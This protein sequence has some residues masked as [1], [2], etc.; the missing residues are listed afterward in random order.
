MLSLSLLSG[1]VSV[2]AYHETRSS[3]SLLQR[4]HLVESPPLPSQQADRSASRPVLYFS[5]SRLALSDVCSSLSFSSFLYFHIFIASVLTT[6]ALSAEVGQNWGFPTYD[7]FV[8]RIPYSCPP[9]HL[10][11]AY[12]Y[13]YARWLIVVLSF[14]VSQCP[15]HSI[16]ATTGRRWNARVSRGGNAV[17]S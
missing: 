3:V 6:H 9:L 14:F 7:P 4:G 10:K 2:A 15:S 13:V 11:I 8:L 16:T 12:P 1:Y 5:C 17:S